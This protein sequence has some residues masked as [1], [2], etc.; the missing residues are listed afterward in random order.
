[1]ASSGPHGRAGRRRHRGP[2]SP[3]ALAAQLDDN[4]STLEHLAFEPAEL[5]EI[6]RFAVEGD[7]N[8]WAASTNA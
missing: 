8:L 7:V 3:T 5:A 1:M 6:D 4:L 2:R